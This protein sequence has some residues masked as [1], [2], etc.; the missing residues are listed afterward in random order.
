MSRLFVRKICRL[1]TFLKSE[2]RLTMLA[3]GMW[4]ISELKS[5]AVRTRQRDT[6]RQRKRADTKVEHNSK[7]PQTELRSTQ[8]LRD[9]GE[10]VVGGVLN[11]LP[12]LYSAVS[13]LGNKHLENLDV[14]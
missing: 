5:A 6:A 11:V 9:V 13:P 14:T 7:H 4:E 2:G 12:D 8:A 3:R 1:V 10:G